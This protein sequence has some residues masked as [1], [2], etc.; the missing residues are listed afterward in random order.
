MGYYSSSVTSSLPVEFQNFPLDIL[1]TE[2]PE[3]RVE[4]DHSVN[5]TGFTQL[6]HSYIAGKLRLSPLLPTVPKGVK[7]PECVVIF[8]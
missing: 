5:E 4:F 8:M 3:G 6:C 1:D 2:C 7:N